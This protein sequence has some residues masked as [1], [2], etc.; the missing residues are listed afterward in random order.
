M[1]SKNILDQEVKDCL[2]FFGEVETSKI[3]RIDGKAMACALRL[4]FYAG[5]KK[6][7]IPFLKI[8]DIKLK[9]GQPVQIDPG[10][11]DIKGKFIELPVSAQE[12]L[13]D[14]LKDLLPKGEVMEENSKLFPAYV[15]DSGMKKF[16]RHLQ[17]L[18]GSLG[19]SQWV[20]F[21]DIRKLGKRYHRYLEK[22]NRTERSTA[23]QFRLKQRSV[24]KEENPQQDKPSKPPTTITDRLRVVSNYLKEIDRTNRRYIHFM[25]NYVEEKNKLLKSFFGEKLIDAK[26]TQGLKEKNIEVIRR[27]S[28]LYN[29]DLKLRSLSPK[30]SS[31]SKIL[32]MVEPKNGKETIEKLIWFLDQILV[33]PISDL[34]EVNIFRDIFFETLDTLEQD[35]KTKK[36]FTE[37]FYQNFFHRNIV[38]KTQFSVLYPSDKTRVSKSSVPLIEATKIGFRERDAIGVSDSDLISFLEKY[39]NDDLG[40]FIS[41]LASAKKNN[42]LADEIAN[43]IQRVKNV[44]P[45]PGIRKL[46]TYKEVLHYIADKLGANPSEG[47]SLERLET[48]INLKI[49]GDEYFWDNLRLETLEA[50]CG[51]Q[52][53]EMNC[54]LARAFWKVHSDSNLPGDKG[55]F[56]LFWTESAED[57][58]C[59]VLKGWLSRKSGSMDPS[60][61]PVVRCIAHISLLRQLK[62]SK[63]HMKYSLKLVRPRVGRHRRFRLLRVPT[64]KQTPS[65]K[66][67]LLPM[68]V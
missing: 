44:I 34:Q 54:L 36:A 24:N 67:A 22:K 6:K 65:L 39:G 46:C 49:L 23:E 45:F 53:N 14:Y 9:N 66:P 38:F 26:I 52:A 60:F 35:S 32:H 27:L 64:P 58:I 48:Q 59:K 30:I 8:R 62:S 12:A 33:I 43:H 31:Q 19:Y 25:D 10:P 2:K 4:V 57:D 20:R 68:V 28:Q 5:V 17:A 41:Y 40:P 63:T 11:L 56:P 16:D 50:F 29:A 15:G 1:S 55:T 3:P 21:K 42:N 61:L 51:L 7:E 13:I 18:Q 37:S 47:E